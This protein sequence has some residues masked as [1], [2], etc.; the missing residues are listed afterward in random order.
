[1]FTKGLPGKKAHFLIGAVL[2]VCLAW[3]PCRAQSL[4]S[5]KGPVCVLTDSVTRQSYSLSPERSLYNVVIT[6]GLAYIQLTQLF[7]NTFGNIKDIAYVF[8]LPNMGS[9]HS[10]AMEYRDSLYQA[11]I[12]RKE[13][14][15]A[16]YDSVVQ[17]GGS[18]ALL[19]QTKPNIFQQHLANIKQ[20]DS[21]YVR[22]GLVVPLKYD[23]GVFELAVPTMIGERYQS[24]G[25]PYVP[26]SGTLWNPPENRDG[27]TIQ[28]NVLI[29]TGYPITGLTSPTHPFMTGGLDVMRQTLEDR[30]VMKQEDKVE[31]P[32]SCGGMLLSQT[33]YPN[34]DFVLRFSR[35]A[36]DR[37]FTL[38]SYYDTAS[39]VGHFAMNI[40]PDTSLFKGT[41]P[42]LD[43]VLLVDISGS[44]AGWPL[45][46]EKEIC[47]SILGRLL[48]TDRLAVLAFNTSQYWAFG[49]ANAV[50]ASAAN[51]ATA[52][53]F[54]N[55][56]A[57][58]GGTDLL[59]GVNAAL[60]T[61]QTSG[62]ERYYVFLTDGFVTN[63]EAIIAAIRS[64]PSN[65]TVFTF[66][67]GNSINRYLIDEAA[68]TGNGG[69]GTVIT[70]TEAVTPFVDAAWQKIETPQLKN[71]TVDFGSAGADFIVMPSGANL[72][73]GRPVEVYGRYSTGGS[74][75]VTV[76]GDCAGSPVE[77]KK[78]VVFASGENM[79]V[80]LPQV[81]ARELIE[82]LSIE[83][84][85]TDQYKETIVEL[86]LTYQVLSKYT[87]FL[88]ITPQPVNSDES[89]ES[90]MQNAYKLDAQAPGNS[91]TLR[92][93]L[94]SFML[95]I[96]KGILK[97]AMPAN[98]VMKE[99]R[100]FDVSGKCLYSF[101]PPA[102]AQVRQFEWDGR[103]ENGVRLRPGCYVA[104]VK[105][106][107]K[108]FTAQFVWK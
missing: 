34:R 52:K 14:A 51:V 99:F 12:Y 40:F 82:E 88:A 45:D 71:I 101:K 13:E 25:Q 81:W 60:A 70:Q 53:T 47:Q 42:D 78:T 92:A 37:D 3:L 43:I 108:M 75:V 10:M 26:S 35:G 63:E 30:G 69:Y 104:T 17:A 106:D 24:A 77:I 105:A 84:G 102:G 67:C 54:I 15:Q 6:D 38:A 44:Q 58:T 23:N 98:A 56:L 27:Q 96:L 97:I 39:G 20:G 55:G 83:E 94:K 87:A 86:S 36:S 22:I 68:N 93:K 100:V 41:R 57:S 76:T 21:A 66:G 1:M 85:T 18:G 73:V 9:V 74:A 80:M 48:P 5:I 32:Y 62:R 31:R 33:T 11:K 107:A 7:V 72:F 64:H 95:C 50:D 4:D 29:Q 16:K 90:Q 19:T 59:A 8:P 61:P 79:N 49:D 46:K 65:P 91:P 28:I 2:V 103:L 89:M